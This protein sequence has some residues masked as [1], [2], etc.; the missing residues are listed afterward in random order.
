MLIRSRIAGFVNRVFLSKGGIWFR[1][2]VVPKHTNILYILNGP[3][4]KRMLVGHNIVTDA[5]DTWYAQSACG[6]TL[7]ND[8]NDMFLST[9]AFSPSPAKGTDAGDLAST[10]S[11]GE[12]AITATFPKS[13]DADADNTGSGVDVVTHQFSYAKGDFNDAT[14]E[15][16]TIAVSGTTFGSGTDPLLNA[17][18]ETAFAKTADDTLKVIINHTMNGV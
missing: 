17:R 14:I 12:K 4:G 15:G 16:V 5:G 13:N 11:G 2:L 1:D 6:E 3:E 10:I 18:N 7:T 8:F 9:V